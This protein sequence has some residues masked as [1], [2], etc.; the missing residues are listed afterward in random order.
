MVMSCGDVNVRLCTFVFVLVVF[1]FVLSRGYCWR[2]FAAS[3][4]VPRS[5]RT[6]GIPPMKTEWLL[7]RDI[8]WRHSQIGLFCRRS[9]SCRLADQSLGEEAMCKSYLDW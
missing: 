4:Y 1:L 8:S 5:V 7:P 9:V 6:C 3:L 2:K